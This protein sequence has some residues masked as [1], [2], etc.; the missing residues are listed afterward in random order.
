MDRGCDEKERQ[1]MS[2]NLFKDVSDINAT[3]FADCPLS[4]LNEGKS[5]DERFSILHNKL[6]GVEFDE[7]TTPFLKIFGVNK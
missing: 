5:F 2:L 6:E 7:N 3:R 1:D 4:N